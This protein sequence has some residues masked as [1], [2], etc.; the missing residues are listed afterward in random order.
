[1]MDGPRVF[2]CWVWTGVTYVFLKKLSPRLAWWASN[3]SLCYKSSNFIGSSQKFEAKPGSCRVPSKNVEP[4]PSKITHSLGRR[5][6]GL[7][8]WPNIT[9]DRTR[10]RRRLTPARQ[11]KTKWK[12]KEPRQETRRKRPPR[13][14]QRLSSTQSVYNSTNSF[15]DFFGRA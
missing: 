4:E 13:E 3:Q 15:I 14:P 2:E 8:P 9:P 10:R 12:Y 7:M 11:W 6:A 1:M 5:R